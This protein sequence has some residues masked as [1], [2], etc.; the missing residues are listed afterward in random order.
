[1]IIRKCKQFL[2][3]IL[4]F[5]LAF[6]LLGNTLAL[7]HDKNHEIYVA[8]NSHI[9]TAWG[10]PVEETARDVIPET[11]NRALNA[12]RYSS[13]YKFSTS[14]SQHYQWAKE[15]YPEMYEEIKDFVNKGQW[16][17]V[18]G[19]A[20]EP[21]LNMAGG[22]ALVRQSL[23]GQKFFE[24]EFG[25][26]N[27]S[28]FVPDV[29]GFSGQM[30]QILSKAGMENFVTTKLNWNDTNKLPG[31]I[32]WWRGIDGSKVLFYKPMIDYTMQSFSPSQGD[33]MLDR[34]QSAGVNRAFALFGS[35]DHGGG[36]LLTGDTN[37]YNV[38][39]GYDK[40]PAY[41]PKIKISTVDEYFDTVRNDDLSNVPVIDGEMYFEYHRGTYT[42][43]ARIKEYNRKNEILAEEAEKADTIGKWLGVV[44]GSPEMIKT[45]WD[46]ILVNQMHD[47]LPGSSVP[48][49]YDVTINQQELVRNIL[50]NVKN[51][52][53]Q[54]IAYKADTDIQNGEPVFVFNPLS[55]TRSEFVEVKLQ[56]ETEP[57]F[58]R[59]Y[60]LDGNE[61][62]STVVGENGSSVTVR[63]MAEDIPSVGYK[64]FSAVSSGE[65]SALEPLLSID[66]YN[67][68]NSFYKVVINP[69]TGNIS[70]IYNKKDDN[71]DILNG[72]G[73]ELHI[74]TDTGG[75]S[76]PAWDVI[77]SE[78]N[79]EPTYVLNDTPTSI[80]VIENT[81]TKAVIRVTRDWSN[82]KFIQDITMYADTD[83]ID[84]KMA[85]DWHE[86]NRLLK[87]SFPLRAIANNATYETGY[88]AVQRPT[89]RD[90]SYGR[91][92]FEVP[93]HKWADVTNEADR[94]FGTSILNDSKYGWDALLI[95]DAE[96]NPEATRLRLTLLRSAGTHS[97]GSEWQPMRHNEVDKGFYEFTYSI[98]PHEGDCTDANTVRKANQLNYPMI[99]FQTDKHGGSL[100][101]EN[102]FISVDSPNVVVT[103]VKSVWDDPKSKDLIVRLYEAHG[104]EQTTANIRFP[105][106]VNSAKEVN[107][108]EKPMA[109]AKPVNI[110]G[111]SVTA[112]FGKYEIKTLR[113]SLEDFEDRPISQTAVPVDLYTYFNM[114]G[115][116]TNEDR[117]DGN[118]D[119][120]GNTYPAELWPGNL[121]LQGVPF[122]LGPVADGYNNLVRAEGQTIPLSQGK[123]KYVY[124]LGTASESEESGGVFQVKYSD[125]DTTEKNISFA[126]WNA[127]L[128]GWDRYSR[129][130]AAPM[131]KDT[132]AYVFTHYH[133][134][135]AD[136][137]TEENQLYLYKIPVDTTKDVKEITLPDAPGIKIAAI[138]MADSDF[139]RVARLEDGALLDNEPPTQVTNVSATLIEDGIYEVAV[140]WDEAKDN[141]TILCYEIYRGLDADFVP[142]E[143]NLVATVVG[144]M[145]KYTDILNYSGTYY[146]KI[147]AVD[148]S[149]NSS[150]SEASG[151][152][153]FR[154][155]N[156]CLMPQNR[157]TAIGSISSEPPWMACDGTVENN[158]KWCYNG[159]SNPAGDTNPYW[160]KVNL[161]DDYDKWNIGAFAVKH[162]QAGGESASWNTRD[163]T[164]QISENDRD[165]ED[166]VTVT[167]NTEAVTIHKLAEP[168]TA[169]YIRLRI[170]HPGQNNCARIY[171][172]QAWGEY[173]GEKAPNAEDVHIKSVEKQND[174][175]VLTADY[176]FI[177][178]DPN[179][180]EMGSTY[181]WYASET[182]SEPYAEMSGEAQKVLKLPFNTTYK[183]IIFEVT[184]KDNLENRG[185]AVTTVPVFIGP[186]TVADR[187]YKRP[188]DANGWMNDSEGPWK[189]VD[190]DDTTK[191]CYRG[192][193]P[194]T[195][196]MDM[197]GIYGLSRFKIRHSQ[198]IGQ[199]DED[200][201][202]NQES[203]NTRDFEIALS[204]DGVDWKEPV[205][206]VDGNTDAITTHLVDLDLD[207]DL[208]IGRY[209]RLKINKSVDTDETYECARIYAFEAWGS[210]KYDA[211]VQ[212]P[213]DDE[214]T[215]IKASGVEILGKPEVMQVL[216]GSYT[217]QE[218]YEKY[219]RFRWMQGDDQNGPWM[220]IPNAN[221]KTFVPTKEYE[222]KYILFEVRV[223]L[224][225]TVASDYVHIAAESE[226]NALLGSR[227]SANK[228]S[229]GHE[230]ELVLDGD[231]ST[232]WFTEGDDNTLTVVLDTVYNIN[233]FVVKHAATIREFKG[234]TALNT[235][236]FEILASTNGTDWETVKTVRSNP[237]DASDIILETPVMAKYI[238]LHVSKSCYAD[239]QGVTAGTRINEFAAY[240]VPARMSAPEIISVTIPSDAETGKLLVADYRYDDPEGAWEGNSILQWMAFDE[241]AGY[242]PIPGATSKFFR[243][244]KDL[245]GKYILFTVI[246]VNTYGV[247]G[248]RA[249][250]NVVRV[251]NARPRIENVKIE[252]DGS[253][254][255]KLTVSYTYYDVE[256]DTEGATVCQWYRSED[257]INFTP[258]SGQ[259]KAVLD[260]TEV[261]D[262]RPGITSVKC[263]I[264]PYQAD[265]YAGIASD[266]GTFTIT[267]EGYDV[268]KGKTI[269]SYSSYVNANEAPE[270]LIDGDY[271][272]KWCDN[273][274][275]NPKWVTVDLGANRMLNTFVL[276]NCKTREPG[277]ANARSFRIQVSPDNRI[278]TNVYRTTDNTDNITSVELDQP[279]SARYVR[280]M[281]DEPATA[282][283]Y[284]L[285]AWGLIQ[286]TTLELDPPKQAI[287]GGE[288]FTMKYGVSVTD[289]VYK[290]DIV[291]SYDPAVFTFRED[292]LTT[293]QKDTVINSVY[294]WEGN[295]EISLEHLKDGLQG[296][297]DVLKLGFEAKPILE[298]DE[299]ESVISMTKASF[300]RNDGQV[301]EADYASLELT[302][303]G[304]KKALSKLV[305][306]AKTLYESAEIGIE[307]G[308][309]FRAT[310]EELG[311]QIAEAEELLAQDTGDYP[312]MKNKLTE[313]INDF[314]NTIITDLTGDQ[315]GDS[316]IDVGDL[317]V[318]RMYYGLSSSDLEG[319]EKLADVDYD[320]K[321][322]LVDLAFAALRIGK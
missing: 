138:S 175:L 288:L 245:V 167:G 170:T 256:G 132:V 215:D 279:V 291:I 223:G 207:P 147:V 16:N 4:I 46:K 312:G 294:D 302:V 296:N 17:V 303:M 126:D 90:D 120:K 100:E 300:V 47:I 261:Q 73:N 97:S 163:F 129:T 40:D 292:M 226:V 275:A 123:Y 115:V 7:A 151:P 102:S 172:F 30:P 69:Q 125:D 301:I 176:T 299:A 244:T 122:T 280:L 153:E 62:P 155:D 211:D 217:V 111:N 65:P 75:S 313:A 185:K 145:Q 260:I 127:K 179:M 106:T 134:P 190:G 259:T 6:S 265:G 56:F 119:G 77:E 133:M 88:G 53:L 149:G 57:D 164:I 254:K 255:G 236:D 60:D 101:N 157:I 80:D 180:V 104:K 248:L 79:K 188:T 307:N 150:V 225:D 50:N 242:M 13:D 287:A 305:E 322:G 24:K 297:V 140:T 82:S 131:I 178:W 105:N 33:Q 212:I 219:C 86:R 306:D 210:P 136:R 229:L 67:M 35:G 182:G 38:I 76:W 95:K 257:G 187:V 63:F 55:W 228:Q 195:L 266:S 158:S 113:V 92:R 186:E 273:A 199:Y 11:Y 161:G 276:R 232:Y 222:G 59:I 66:G 14:A 22:E 282:R 237:Y 114:D 68:E 317:N 87:V 177:P 205:V 36:P 181:K 84:V 285:E 112:D 78:L 130:Y 298:A 269:I 58:V 247:K 5:V 94:A 213:D 72:E 98:Y 54:A 52:G 200:N 1:M 99:A 160:L 3:V 227:I 293:V 197:G 251:Q 204:Y 262:I 272:T 316:V 168:E 321:V 202:D 240:G 91:A 174:E 142:G 42:S 169:R 81:P 241:E 152:V 208:A 268:I 286:G 289:A 141:D 192:T 171:E 159:G 107:L 28:G 51:Y 173:T 284:E 238:K 201:V 43:W 271:T 209:V 124:L 191:W 183:S 9:D 93:G 194:H 224:G 83:R 32:W 311:R 116:S 31:D 231:D 290:Q 118:L 21:D 39:A 89:T 246:P 148:P 103:V 267:P 184:P 165:W 156:A 281:I 135:H 18:G 206:S 15:Y 10:W 278:W 263:R 239:V 2:A 96:G 304:S 235:K 318:I 70:H 23:H 64:V 44:P 310:V 139:L 249:S 154:M 220:P 34:V 274:S 218:Q 85:V 45:A 27:K 314:L 109:D 193:D 203:Y 189:A 196:V 19:Q 166:I 37:N 29:F 110:S 146:Y 41:G 308:M 128:S 309:Y 74:Y 315:N 258:I 243:P 264:T 12:L 270:K 20:V 277:Y 121:S 214:P 26:I 8:P 283:I 117:T 233:R 253:V 144:T 71:R 137:M 252:G 234:L 143:D 48:Y 198:S 162:A 319:G 49:Q 108:L 320:G 295:I 230:A 216:T 221:G 250:S 25:R 61:V